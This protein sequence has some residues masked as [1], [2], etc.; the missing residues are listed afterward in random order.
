MKHFGLVSIAITVFLLL[1]L[2]C[3]QMTSSQKNLCFTLATQ[4]YSYVPYCETES[5]CYEKVSEM[6][7][8]QLG[9]EQE[10]LL[11]DLK[12]SLARSWFFHNKAIKETETIQKLCQ[13]GNAKGLST[14]LNQSRYY[15]QQALIELDYSMKKSFEIIKAEEKMLSEENIE[16]IKEDE[17]YYSL[18][19]FRQI[20][21]ELNSGETN[22][23]TYFSYY[24][25]KVIEFTKSSAAKGFPIAA[26]KAPVWIAGFAYLDKLIIFDHKESTLGEYFQSSK[27]FGSL[28]AYF[29]NAFFTRETLLNLQNFPINDF[30]KLYSNI[31]GNNNSAIKRFSDL[32][33]K[34][35]NNFNTT[36]KYS[37]TG[38][39]D[40]EQKYVA[41]S[42]KVAEYN[43]L[44]QHAKLY[45]LLFG[46]VVSIEET[47]QTKLLQIGTNIAKLKEKI[48]K[49]DVGIGER[50]FE[51]KNLLAAENS[52]LAEVNIINENALDQTYNK[53]EQ[54][55][56]NYKNP[57]ADE[58]FHLGDLADEAYYFAQKTKNSLNEEKLY[59]CAKFV[60]KKLELEKAISNYDE[61]LAAQKILAQECLTN[62]EKML[63]Y[64][65]MPELREQYSQL[66]E[67]NITKLNLPWAINYCLSISNQA[68]AQIGENKEIKEL[69]F[70]FT[71]LKES[72][73]ILN[74]NIVVIS[75]AGLLTETKEQLKKISKYNDYFSPDGKI[76]IENILGIE[77]TLLK[78]IQEQN[79]T[80]N[81]FL[82]KCVSKIIKSNYT[83][84]LDTNTI[85]KKSEGFE[86][87]GL[88]YFTNPIKNSDTYFEID[89]NFLL[90]YLEDNSCIQQ[91]PF[92]RQKIVFI[93]ANPGPT[94]LKIKIKS[95]LIQVEGDELIKVTNNESI[96][97]RT[98]SFIPENIFARAIITTII[99]PKT[100]KV[101]VS[102]EHEEILYSINKSTLEIG[103]ALL[104]T[105]KKIYATFFTTGII[106]TSSNLIKIDSGSGFDKYTFELTAQSTFPESLA[107]DLLF[108]I[109]ELEFAENISLQ[110]DSFNQIE[111][112]R[113]ANKLFIE[114]SHF[115][116]K[117]K[118]YF[119]LSF[120]VSDSKEAYKL[121][122]E[123]QRDFF[124]EQNML[125]EGEKT[126]EFISLIFDKSLIEIAKK[127]ESNNN[128]IENQKL[129]VLNELT[130]NQLQNNIETTLKQLYSD[131]NLLET[132]G[133]I[134]DV[135]R[136]KEL[137]EL[138]SSGAIENYSLAQL[139]TLQ[140][141]E[142]GIKT[143]ILAE[144][145]KR[146]LQMHATMQKIM[147]E[148]KSAS[149]ILTFNDFVK[150]KNEF[151]VALIKSQKDAYSI[152]S[153]LLGLF[154][155]FL[156]E[157]EKS[158]ETDSSFSPEEEKK[159]KS[160]LSDSNKLIQNL[161]TLLYGKESELINAKFIQPITEKRLK[162]LKFNLNELALSDLNLSVKLQTVFA[163][164]DE[165]LTAFD[166]IK[167]QTITA[168]NSAVDSK[169]DKSIVSKSKELIDSNKF[170]DA[171]LLLN[172]KA[173]LSESIPYSGFI[174]IALIIVVAVVL[175]QK[176][177][178]GERI[179]KDKREK[180]TEE[181]EKI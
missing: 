154:D 161:E 160:L 99:P 1:L 111:N 89:L 5:S 116:P 104:D 41:C 143:K 144:M 173:P 43:S 167:R 65:N 124:Y 44:K 42:K 93:C 47:P 69:E 179:K 140:K 67:T 32:M 121:I 87:E 73:N 156:I 12:N 172:S 157:K 138:V 134:E 118:K 103:P 26:E 14:P 147:K 150:K 126:N 139:N 178:S 145:Q 107:A 84:L 60:A 48:A 85:I 66:K 135:K 71:K 17:L 152:Y 169:K 31:G 50:V 141:E 82:D 142:A 122:L 97:Q 102:Y 127:I 35:S 55:A 62:L 2:G 108:E 37:L 36:K 49:E 180:L 10:S 148:T 164:K 11:Y 158:F 96:I 68:K 81:E 151:D 123:R 176:F 171:F 113:L 74:Q 22:S 30:M 24:Q 79:I 9:Y 70:E 4:S 131:V 88:L 146:V 174:P 149:L 110:T 51:I 137:N 86:Q 95:N 46:K 129:T 18:I 114:N 15:M 170:T 52:L 92:S 109:D 45:S 20:I 76:I 90:T 53:C 39:Q 25:N 40:I 78:S 83:I 136:I 165:L 177:N 120:E 58:D 105:K 75:G 132:I 3:T 54:I 7:K 91:D 61:Y 119:T 115:L 106:Q 181:W 72:E 29:E 59:Y 128:L 159:F 6:F 175:L 28:A 125:I 168:F 101:A 33:N 117:E 133:F 13:T 56:S 27:I 77:E 8:T 38:M 19:E 23:N 153:Q 112:K 16:L 34:T 162:Q 57:V 166:S 100:N 130:A 63:S 98:I 155:K 163:I 94:A 80:V 21:S 64:K